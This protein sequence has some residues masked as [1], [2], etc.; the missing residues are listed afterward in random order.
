[1]GSR[2]ETKTQAETGLVFHTRWLSFDDA[3]KSILVN[4]SS[5][6]SV[7]VADKSAKAVGL[8]KSMSCFK[9]LYT[10][11]F[12]ADVMHYL[13]RFFKAYQTSDIS[14]NTVYPLLENTVRKIHSLENCS[15]ENITAFL[16]CVP[17]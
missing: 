5:L 6:L 9:F 7:L 2:S 14:F 17:A 1:M 10:A 13:C 4:Y 11:H 3:L 12:L 8:V 15:G 16:Q